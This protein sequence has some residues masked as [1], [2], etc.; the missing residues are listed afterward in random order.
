MNYDYNTSQAVRS[1]DE[2][3]AFAEVQEAKK[4]D[5]TVGAFD[6]NF[7]HNGFAPQLEM[8]SGETFHLEPGAFFSLFQAITPV[9]DFE[10]SL[11][12]RRVSRRAASDLLYGNPD[13]VDY[14][15][16]S[17]KLLKNRQNKLRLYDSGTNGEVVRA[18]VGAN[19]LTIDTLQLLHSIGT[20]HRNTPIGFNSFVSRD[21]LGVQ[22]V[23]DA[24]NKGSY[25]VGALL[26]NSELG[27]SAVSVMPM[28][29]R[30]VCSNSLIIVHLAASRWVHRGTNDILTNF[31]DRLNDS[32]QQSKL[33]V[34]QLESL[35]GVKFPLR[36]RSYIDLTESFCRREG[37]SEAFLETMLLGCEGNSDMYGFVNG[38]THAAKGLKFKNR[39]NMESLAGKLMYADPAGVVK[40]YS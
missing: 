36:T 34:D 13:S 9:T 22:L 38:I 31:D 7:G 27:N 10:K 15:N 12:R 16:H 33:S 30:Q 35:R 23:I 11:K 26:R 19:Y 25:G 40:K 24:Y 21:E 2:A 3:L 18:V 14:L 6:W 28:I 5:I 39:H 8:S 17:K 32:V 37:Q 20:R 29:Q 1:L 4:R